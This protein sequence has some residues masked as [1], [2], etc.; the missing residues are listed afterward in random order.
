MSDCNPTNVASCWLHLV[1]IIVVYYASQKNTHIHLNY[2]EDSR[3]ASKNDHNLVFQFCLV[4]WGNFLWHLISD[5]RGFFLCPTFLSI[6]QGLLKLLPS[7]DSGPACPPGADPTRHAWIPRRSRFATPQSWFH[8][9]TGPGFPWFP[10]RNSSPWF[11]CR[12]LFFRTM[13]G[14][15]KKNTGDTTKALEWRTV[16]CISSGKTITTLKNYQLYSSWNTSKYISKWLFTQ[17]SAYCE[18]KHPI[19]SYLTF[20]S[21][22]FYV[23]CL[24]LTHLFSSAKG[25]LGSKTKPIDLDVQ[26]SPSQPIC[27]A[28]KDPTKSSMSKKITSCFSLRKAQEKKKTCGK[29]VPDMF[30]AASTSPLLCPT[31]ARHKKK[32]KMQG[33]LGQ[34]PNAPAAP[35]TCLETCWCTGPL[36]TRAGESGDANDFNKPNEHLSQSHSKNPGRNHVATA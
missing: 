23:W 7:P 2:I 10:T 18:N 1:H 30:M 36:Q 5:F 29:V 11:Q 3:T 15:P 24:F 35:L 12:Q 4:C 6:G 22:N 8:I 34:L 9:T 14:Y 21:P 28:E 19:S 31:P 26:K 16:T 27:S 32:R 33:K 25:Q 13:M 17:R 20:Q